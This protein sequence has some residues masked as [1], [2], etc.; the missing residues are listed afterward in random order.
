M[1][2]KKISDL[3]NTL[4]F[5]LTVLYATAFIFIAILAFFTFYWYLHQVT[6]DRLDEELVDDTEVYSQLLHKTNLA[7]LKTRIVAQFEAEDRNEEF[8]R[9]IDLSGNNS[10]QRTCPDGQGW[11]PE[12]R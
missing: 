2:L 6:M 10:L 9:L 12:K 8:V 7:G 11:T 3:K 4:F 1:S 5:R